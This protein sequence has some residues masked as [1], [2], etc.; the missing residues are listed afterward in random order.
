MPTR[1]AKCR[2]LSELSDDIGA[3]SREGK[4]EKG[5]EKSAAQDRC[6]DELLPV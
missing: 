6:Q 2:D 1:K 3:C 5:I 4:L